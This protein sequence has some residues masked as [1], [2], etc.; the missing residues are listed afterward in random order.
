MTVKTKSVS[1]ARHESVEKLSLKCFIK[2]ERIITFF[3]TM[4]K[5]ASEVLEDKH[6]E[7]DVAQVGFS[8]EDTIF[9]WVKYGGIWFSKSEGSEL[10]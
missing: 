4:N 10:P 9:S 8:Q 7:L 6:V 2:C 5:S 3:Q 1:F